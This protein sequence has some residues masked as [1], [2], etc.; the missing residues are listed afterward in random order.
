MKECKYFSYE[1][2]CGVKVKKCDQNKKVTHTFSYIF[3][4]FQMPGDNE[5]SGL[6]TSSLKGCY[7]AI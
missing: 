4:K 1:L 7:K 6:M 5:N 3:K 2:L